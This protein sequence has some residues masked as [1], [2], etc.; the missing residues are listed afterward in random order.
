MIPC[1]WQAFEERASDN[2]RDLSGKTQTRT[3][4]QPDH[5]CGYSSDPTLTCTAAR[6]EDDQDPAPNGYA[7]VP[8]VA[9]TQTR[10]ITETREESD[11]DPGRPGLSAVPRSSRAPVQATKTVTKQRE[12]PEQDESG[13]RL[14]AIPRAGEVHA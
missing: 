8:R 13:R 9:A 5:R 11:Q 7:A 14:A 1:F 10:T 6:E 3:R 2:S 4:E 12:E